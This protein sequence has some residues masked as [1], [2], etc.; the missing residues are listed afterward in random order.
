MREIWLLLV[1]AL[2]L[3]LAI[4]ARAADS[5]DIPVSGSE[6]PN[7]ASFDRLMIDFVRE[8]QAPGAALAVT[9]HGQLV[10][11]RGFGFADREKR[12][13]V[14]PQAL[15]RIASISKPFTSAAIMQLVEKGK[16]RLEDHP[17]EILGLTPPAGQ[18]MDPRLRQIT[19]LQLLQHTG[20]FDRDKSFDPM[21]RS[22]IIA[23]ELKT[24]PPA[25][26][27]AII[28]YM[29]G[30]P[31]DFDPGTR[32]AYSNFGYC[33]LGRVIEKV[34][35]ESYEQYVRQHVLA[36]L[37]IHDMRLGHTLASLR[38]PGEAIYYDQKN[39]TGASVFPPRLGQQVPTPYGAWDMEAMD[40]HGGW[41]ASAVDLVRFA[42]SFDDPARSRILSERSI[43]TIFAPPSGEVG[44]NADGKTKVVYYGC[45]WQVRQVGGGRINAWHNG[46]LD[47]TSTLLVRRADGLCWAVL[48]N[49]RKDQNGKELSGIIDPLVHKAADEVK[50]WPQA[51]LFER[52]LRSAKS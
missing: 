39:R 43:K 42:S 25:S 10:Y 38:A 1:V 51:D 52:Y 33:V 11:A 35:G 8:H 5:P 40:S 20:G 4:P 36:P 24:N 34:S 23:R 27:E 6:N 37:N 21:F 32:E 2:V 48:F 18:Q 14:K 9:R 28:R 41:I 17:F 12:E 50:Q 45:G 16:L 29:L 49:T 13:L 26:Q 44:H 19:I 47:G 7:L 46:S 22:I 30:R 3:D 31:L 15:F